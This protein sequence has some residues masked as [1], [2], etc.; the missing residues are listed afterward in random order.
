MPGDEPT[1]LAD[2]GGTN[3]RFTV[4]AQGAIDNVVTY[5]A[6]AFPGPCAAIERFLSEHGSGARPR[7]AAIAAAGPVTDGEIVLTNSD[8]RIRAA[9]L[10]AAF[11][12][13]RVVLLH[14]FAAV[15][16]AVPWL[17][18]PD[19]LAIGGGAAVEGEQIAVMG[20]GTGLGMAGLLR[21]PSGYRV[22]SSE[23]GHVTMAAADDREAAIL[24]RVRARFGHASAERVL[25]GDGLVNLYR[26]I[27]EL[28]AEAEAPR[29]D[30]A[31]ICAAAL[32]GDCPLC[33]SALETFC[34]MLGSVAGN[35]ALTLNARGGLYLAGGIVPRFVDFL[36]ASRFRERFEAKG[37]FSSYLASI[38]TSLILHPEPAFLGLLTAIESDLAP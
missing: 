27:A 3:A 15:A 34:A 10:Q 17:A 25:S 36:A 26:A 12:F 8:W 20:A 37:R 24:S 7:S 11:G 16:L 32:A 35:L 9:E 13:E 6:S 23:G 18:V 30:A 29:R 22:L 1:L 31:G 19:L 14:D 5:E 4:G 2:I 21:V 38:P 33:R 28:E